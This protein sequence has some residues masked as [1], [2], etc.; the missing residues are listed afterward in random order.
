MRKNKKTGSGDA[1]LSIDELLQRLK[2]DVA[3]KSEEERMNELSAVY[4][5]IKKVPE[6]NE[7]SIEFL[8]KKYLKNDDGDEIET[9]EKI[10]PVKTQDFEEEENAAGESLPS[11]EPDEHIEQDEAMTTEFLI[12]GVEAETAKRRPMKYRF[13]RYV[14]GETAE[15]ETFAYSSDEDDMPVTET[16]PDY[17]D[18]NVHE[19]PEMPDPS[20]FETRSFDKTE[21]DASDINLMLAFGLEDEL[22]E[23]VGIDKIT[24]IQKKLDSECTVCDTSG[25]EFT[26]RSQAKEVMASFR[27]RY[28]GVKLR[29]ALAIVLTAIIFVFENAGILGISL[30]S[31]LLPAENPLIYVMVGLQL[32]VLCAALA[33]RSIF[34]GAKALFRLRPT[35]ESAA[36]AVSFVQVLYSFLVCGYA[37]EKVRLYSLPAAISICLVLLF[38]YMNLKRDIYSFNIVS[39]NR[40]KYAMS[41]LEPEDAVSEVVALYDSIP[42]VQPG[43]LRVKKTNFVNNFFKRSCVPEEG[44][45]NTLMIPLVIMI[46]LVLFIISFA[47]S[48][49]LVLSLTRAN[50]A[51]LFCMPAVIFIA[52][53]HPLY[54]ASR[55][56]FDNDGAII[57]NGAP[58][59]YAGAS[60]VVFED[61]DIF[62]S[63]GVK[64]KRVKVYGNN[65]I[66]TLLYDLS[67]LFSSVGGPLSDVFHLATLELGQ[68][69]SVEITK[70]EDRGIEALVDGR[71]VLVGKADFIG[72]YDIFVPEDMA[73]F[74]DFESS[75]VSIMYVAQGDVLSA[76]LY[77]QYTMDADFESVI[78]QLYKNGLCAVIKTFD[79]NIDDML[80]SSA[81]RISKYPVKIAKCNLKDKL[82]V[83]EDSLDSGVVSRASTKSLLN[84]MVLCEKLYSAIRTNNFVKVSAFMVSLLLMAF[85]MAFSPDSIALPSV[86]IALYQIFWLLPAFVVTMLFI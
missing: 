2:A 48:R 15:S 36:F 86:Y 40:T 72:A 17:A 9:I 28:S 46:M 80:L 62:P 45:F 20:A 82:G 54:R 73:D 37:D 42:E 71:R 70:A 12:S 75:N 58:A 8:I 25:F 1:D 4:G 16:Q 59:E 33:Y 67:S 29:L 64:V 31:A 65:R 53:A 63:Y 55:K 44:L 74:D 35:P 19:M 22:A 60:A 57:G 66:D 21:L 78:K 41:H 26:D 11:E 52:N 79:P 47:E 14:P 5:D 50:T 39:S 81:I 30:A 83:V 24:E 84:V 6:D 32:F 23:T 49:D 27:R 56:A 68:S 18:A 85:L 69:D 38:E 76:K 77:I 43:I 3:N 13:R 34:S 10:H 61:K 51:F 7:T